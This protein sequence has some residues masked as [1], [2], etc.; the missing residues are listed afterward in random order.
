MKL[1]G[2]RGALLFGTDR[3]VRPVPPVVATSPRFATPAVF[4]SATA[5]AIVRRWHRLDL[6]ELVLALATSLPADSAIDLGIDVGLPALP[7]ERRREHAG[8]PNHKGEVIP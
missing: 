3:L 7:A 6:E 8:E 5:Y 4:S 2:L 1:G